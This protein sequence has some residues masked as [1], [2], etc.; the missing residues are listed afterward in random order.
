MDRFTGVQVR[1]DCS[2]DIMTAIYKKGSLPVELLG[3]EVLY[4]NSFVVLKSGGSQS[5]V[6]RVSRDGLSL[7]LIDTSKIQASGLRPRNKEQAMLLSTLLDPEIP[8]QIITG[9]AGTGKSLLAIAAAMQ[10]IED[11]QY[12]KIILTKPSSQTGKYDLGILPGTIEEKFAPFL[13]NYTSNIEFLLKSDEN[14]RREQQ[15][16]G[17]SK[18]KGKQD[19]P[20]PI[21]KGVVEDFFAQYNVE[22]VPIQLLRGASFH[23]SI[24]LADEVQVLPP[25]D[26]LTIGTRIADSS[27]IVFMGDLAQR[28]D[29]IR[30]Q[31][32]GLH[33]AI[34]DPQM[35]ASGLVAFI[36]LL[37][38]E[39]G[40]VA[41]LF[42]KVFAPDEDS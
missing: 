3:G 35:K 16:S 11:G 12:K 32:T 21:L 20:K 38:V 9:V 14:D 10:L 25:K 31:D 42:A 41:E 24:I 18:L 4:P 1:E 30:R 34:N 33:K 29:P 2:I 27:K 6:C 5:A 17:K 26:L 37:K 39:R 15:K 40:P 23:D 36:E 8:V 19:G 22:M 13:I 7:K 28:D